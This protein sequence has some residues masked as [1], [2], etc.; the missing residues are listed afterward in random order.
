MTLKV[1]PWI[2]G[3]VKPERVGV[4]QRRAGD[5]LPTFSKWDGQQWLSWAC[6]VDDAAECKEVSEFQ[7]ALW[8]GLN[9]KPKD[10]P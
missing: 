10:Q 2:P 1:T 9:A 6:S 5:S 4:Y 7:D 8:R 3:D